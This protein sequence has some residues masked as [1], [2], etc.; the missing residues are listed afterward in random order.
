MFPS[1]DLSLIN[2]TENDEMQLSN[3][4]VGRSFAFDYENKCFIFANGNNKDTTQ[5]DAIK[6]WIELFIRTRSDKFAIYNSDF[7]VRLDGLLGY[8]L[9]RSYVL[10]EIKKR[11][12][13]GILNGCPAV[14]SVTDWVF[15]KGRFSFTVT[16][17]TGEEVK[18]INDI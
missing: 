6:Q 9:P 14:G 18:I 4:H 11:I 12:V 5:V 13:N 8:R 1:I 10:A 15:S 16:T 3:N 7:G 17:N 2:T